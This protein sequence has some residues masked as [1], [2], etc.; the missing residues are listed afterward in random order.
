M[1]HAHEP[2]SRHVRSAAA[3]WQP[4]KE[5]N[6]AVQSMERDEMSQCAVVAPTWKQQALHRHRG[7]SSACW[8]CAIQFEQTGRTGSCS[9][10]IKQ[11]FRRRWVINELLLCALWQAD[12]AC[13]SSPVLLRA[14]S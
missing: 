11:L 8:L 5:R 9:Y 10:C 3:T 12:P 13:Y 2:L 6:C 1:L 4:S 14:S 7:C